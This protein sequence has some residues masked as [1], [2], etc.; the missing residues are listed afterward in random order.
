M[1]LQALFDRQ[2]EAC[3]RLGSPFMARMLR[4]CGARLAPGHP[5]SDRLLQWPGDA[6]AYGDAIALR[7]AGGLHALVLMGRDDGL[8]AAYPPND[9]SD[10]TLW[11]AIRAAMDAHTDHLMHWLDSAPQTN[12]VRRSAAMISAAHILAARCPGL[13]LCLSELGA[14]AGLN[15]F[16]D[17]FALSLPDGTTRGAPQ[18]VLTLSPDWSGP[19]PPKAPFTVAERRGVDLNPL[20]P[21]EPNDVLRLRS[22]TWPD[23]P[24]RMQRLEAALSIADPVVEKGDAAEWLARRLATPMPGRLHLIY[25]TIAWQYF[26]PA[27]DAACRDALATAGAK[28]TPEAP[29][30]HL[31]VEAEGT[32]P[33]ARIRLTLW[34]GEA[35]PDIMD[36]GSMNPHGI[37]LKATD[38]MKG[39]PR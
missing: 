18:P 19:L 31:W 26:P 22:Y 12:E 11:A 20:N 4:I 25:H 2:A 37:T 16:F 29:I 23:Q 34:T 30:A 38:A 35:E 33:N 21:T 24:E 28:A 17:R 32:A 15:L 5:V 14:S 36:L 8:I 1:S 6:T 9:T 3:S 13:P 10:G 7:F 27:T 39:R